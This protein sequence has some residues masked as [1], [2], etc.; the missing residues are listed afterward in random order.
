MAKIFSNGMERINLGEL[1]NLYL[2][3]DFEDLQAIEKMMN[4]IDGDVTNSGESPPPSP[5]PQKKV[6]VIEESAPKKNRLLGLAIIS[7]GGILGASGFLMNPFIGIA[8]V[9]VGS[10]IGYAIQSQIN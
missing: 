9:L 2:D 8:T 10:G 3:Q 4:E 1:G 5:K 7:G 6:S